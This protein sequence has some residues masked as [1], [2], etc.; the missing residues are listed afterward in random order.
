MLNLQI[1]GNEVKEI[2]GLNLWCSCTS[3]KF[4]FLGGGRKTKTTSFCRKWPDFLIQVNDACY[5]SE[6]KG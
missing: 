3:S 2:R 4:V 1:D 5:K 6:N